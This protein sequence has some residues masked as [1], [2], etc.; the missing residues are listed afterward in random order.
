MAITPDPVA[1]G[2][3]D[4]LARPEEILR[5][6]TSANR[7]LSGKR[8][9]LLTAFIPRFS[10]VGILSTFGA[11]K[12]I[13]KG[14]RPKV[15]GVP[16]ADLSKLF[17]VAVKAASV[18]LSQRVFPRFRLTERSLPILRYKSTAVDVR[19][20]D[21]SAGLYIATSGDYANSNCAKW[22]SRYFLI[23]GSNRDCI[24]VI[25]SAAAGAQ[26][27]LLGFRNKRLGLGKQFHD[28]LAALWT[29]AICYNHRLLPSSCL[30]K[31]L[32]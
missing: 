9:E 12:I 16:T 20:R 28:S 8:L 15:S 23:V 27:A 2:L 19:E 17:Q 7:D 5:G 6:L 25:A 24:L 1:S 26:L 29:L 10:R 32:Q 3:V 31:N 21:P 30:L 14:P 22:R 18:Q 11:L 4:S 13:G